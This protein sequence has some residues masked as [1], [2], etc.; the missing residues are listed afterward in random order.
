MP[1]GNCCCVQFP[2]RQLG[3]LCRCCCGTLSLLSSCCTG[4]AR[5]TSAELAQD[6]YPAHTHPP[7][8]VGTRPHLLSLYP[9]SL[10]RPSPSQ[11]SLFA[12]LTRSLA[13][14]RALSAFPARHG[15][16][17]ILLITLLRPPAHKPNHLLLP[18]HT[19]TLAF[20]D[21]SCIFHSPTQHHPLA[22]ADYELDPSSLVHGIRRRP[23]RYKA[24]PLRPSSPVSSSPTPTPAAAHRSIRL[25]S[26]SL[27]HRLCSNLCYEA[28]ICE[29][30]LSR[31]W[32]QLRLQTCPWLDQYFLSSY[33]GT[34]RFASDANPP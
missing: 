7:T 32:L 19:L 33:A 14:T 34:L 12:R 3:A 15:L 25:P 23:V 17:L 30:L 10:R 27:A 4:G 8:F 9:A 1:C 11:I 21:P 18:P 22:A 2:A 31:P 29:N 16:L 24:A 6:L 20:F 13:H 26:L 28:C 5:G